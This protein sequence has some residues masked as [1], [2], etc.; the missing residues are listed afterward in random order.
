M[1]L[2]DHSIYRTGH[3]VDVKGEEGKNFY[4]GGVE[5]GKTFIGFPVQRSVTCL[6]QV[7]I[8]PVN[9]VSSATVFIYFMNLTVLYLPKVTA[10]WDS[11]RV[12]KRCTWHPDQPCDPNPFVSFWRLVRWGFTDSVLAFISFSGITEIGDCIWKSWFNHFL[13]G[14]FIQFALRSLKWE[15]CLRSVLCYNVSQIYPVMVSP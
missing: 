6:S 8:L 1:N 12:L 11:M 15:T 3:Y 7:G 4:W 9:L 13:E 2:R 10:G 14:M 5:G